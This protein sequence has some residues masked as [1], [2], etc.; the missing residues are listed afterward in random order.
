SL[1][2][3]LEVQNIIHFVV[4]MFGTVFI[5]SGACVVNHY[6]E[7]ADDALMN[8][9]KNRP[10]PSGL[11][12][13]NAAL[14]FGILCSVAGAGMLATI[15]ITTLMLALLTHISYVAV[16]TPMKKKTW[17]AMLV[18]GLPGALPAMGGWTAV[19]NAIDMPALV[20]FG[21]MFIWQM[22]HFLAL[23]IM[24]R[25]DYERGGFVLLNDTH[26]R[27]VRSAQHAFAY[28]LLLIP[29]AAAL[30]MLDVTGWLFA[31]GCVCL[32]G[33]FA[34]TALN[35]I[36]DCTTTSARKML[37]SSYIYLMG[38]FLLMFLDKV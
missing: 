32:G 7:R 25:G 34:Y 26:S 17:T 3:F 1:G 9:T 33:Y 35:C 19:T 36:K 21:I 37:I 20:L 30:T 18:G 13:P 11:V 15:N 16:Y 28:S 2:Y 29:C 14:L 12:S 10:I 23:A 6:L 24:Y 31:A 4:M 27:N 38:I 5:S 8:R 22:P